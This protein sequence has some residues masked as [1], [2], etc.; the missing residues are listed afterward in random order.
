MPQIDTLKQLSVKHIVDNSL[1]VSEFGMPF[2]KS[3]SNEMLLKRI[4]YGPSDKEKKLS[5]AE[6]VQNK[7]SWVPGP[8]YTLTQDWPILPAKSGHFNK[9]ARVTS[10]EMIFKKAERLETSSPGPGKYLKD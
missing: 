5:F 1:N 7:K 10:T 9:L 2:Y 8:N 4:Q 3:P 6:Q